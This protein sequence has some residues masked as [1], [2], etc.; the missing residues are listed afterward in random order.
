MTEQLQAEIETLKR[1][2]LALSE[3]LYIVAQHL[4]KLAERPEVRQR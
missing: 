1:L 2:I 3:K 4:A